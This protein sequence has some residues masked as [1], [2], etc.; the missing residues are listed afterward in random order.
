L[1]DDKGEMRSVPIGPGPTSVSLEVEATREI[2]TITNVLGSLQGARPDVVMAGNHRDSWVR[3]AHDAGSGTVTL[4]RAAQHLA[5]QVANGWQPQSTIYLAF[6]DAE[7][8]GLIGSTEWVE[9]HQGILSHALN[10]YINADAAVSGP[11]FRASGSPGLE[12]FLAKALFDM[13]KPEGVQGPWP[14]WMEDSGTLKTFDLP[15]SGS[16]FAPFLHHLCLPVLDISFTGNQ[17]GQYHTAFDDVP[18]VERFLDPGYANH[19]LAGRTMAAMLTTASEMGR[20]VFS[21]WRASQEWARLAREARD[22]MGP[23]HGGG[24][25]A[26]FDRLTKMIARV[27]E[28]GVQ[29]S[30]LPPMMYLGL[31]R[32]EGLPDQPWFRNS[33]WTPDSESGYGSQIFPIMRR[34]VEEGASSELDVEV[35]RL[36]KEIDR[37]TQV[38]SLVPLRPESTPDEKDAK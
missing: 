38:W 25:G 22:W 32:N 21:D 15:G 35:A 24:I 3:G 16:D 28:R 19:E 36:I 7:E 20:G 2:R 29:G 5:E 30:L 23:R 31:K 11:N 6:W 8:Q 1:P 17:G 26:A 34:A 14:T 37:L 12:P 18:M 9:A 10:L 27:Q 33:L 13:P 4:L